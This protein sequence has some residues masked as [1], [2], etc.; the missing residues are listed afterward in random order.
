MQ[1]SSCLRMLDIYTMYDFLHI[2][3]TQHHTSGNIPWAQQYGECG[4]KGSKLHVPFTFLDNLRGNLRRKCKKK[5]HKTVSH[6][7]SS[8]LCWN[9]HAIN[10]VI[11]SHDPFLALQPNGLV[12]HFSCNTYCYL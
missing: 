7:S 8:Y 2:L 12:L 5:S 10:I 4:Q 1:V 6:F 11:S 3:G 9:S